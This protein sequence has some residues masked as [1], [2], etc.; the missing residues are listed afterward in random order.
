MGLFT[1]WF[2]SP[3]S[4]LNRRI[5]R[6]FIRGEKFFPITG[7]TRYNNLDD[8]KEKVNAILTN[9][10]S[11]FIF[12][13]NCDLFSLG[14]PII[15]RN[16]EIL[17]DHPLYNI[18]NN[19]NPYQSQN[20]FLWDYMFWNMTG[21]AN[22]YLESRFD[23]ENNMLM[24]LNN[25]KIDFPQKMID[26]ADKYFKNTIQKLDKENIEYVYDD[27]T[28]QKIAYNKILHFSD[29]TI[30]T[31]AYY[32]GS[33]KLDAL[34][35]IISNSELALDAKNIELLFNGKYMVSGKVNADDINNP[36]MMPDEKKTIETKVLKDQPIT[37]V[38]SMVDIKKF[39]DSLKTK[40]LDHSFLNDA[41]IIGRIYQI[42]KD[43]IQAFYEN[44]AKYENAK[45]ST[46]DH[47][48]YALKPKGDDFMKGIARYFKFN[49]VEVCMD[50]SHLPF[51]QVRQMQKYDAELNRAK[52]LKEL[53]T[54]GVDAEDAQKLLDY[55]F[56]K[57][58]N[59]EQIRNTEASAGSGR[60]NG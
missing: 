21:N 33:S 43:V 27:G 30:T 46:A 13:L 40:E 4:N 2:G 6:D 19:P 29:T 48:D 8:E 57:P 41:Y 47:V 28:R 16:G 60:D 20:Q 54:S 25:S 59:Y 51:M 31:N 23:I 18:L 44:G 53:L 10:A 22:L 1:N 38:R 37:A 24:F 15:K 36:M 56:E 34:Y 5:H 49:D 58:I 32:K 12:T 35:K 26:N 39:I 45:L 7:N 50:W 14:E 52:A 17:E 11:L 9:P 42:P 3:W 55:E